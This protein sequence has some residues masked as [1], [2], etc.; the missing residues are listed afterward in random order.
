MPTDIKGDTDMQVVDNSPD[1][2][3]LLVGVVMHAHVAVVVGRVGW[4][5]AQ[6]IV[7]KGSRQGAPSLFLLTGWRRHAT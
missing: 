5:L 2:M 3:Q 4:H 6:N 1:K 7:E